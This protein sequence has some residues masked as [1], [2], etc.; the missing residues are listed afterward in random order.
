[1]RQGVKVK[2][3]TGCFGCWLLLTAKIPSEPFVSTPGKI[4]RV[5]NYT[6][7]NHF[8]HT[9]FYRMLVTYN[10]KQYFL[11]KTGVCNFQQDWL[12]NPSLSLKDTAVIEF[13]Y[14][15]SGFWRST[16]KVSIALRGLRIWQ[17]DVCYSNCAFVVTANVW[18]S[19]LWTRRSANDKWQSWILESWSAK[20][21]LFIRLRRDILGCRRW[22]ISARWQKW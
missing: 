11:Y 13:G 2:I 22:F 12:Q 17:R 1:M 18:K 16:Y 3:A 14:K 15:G 21:G 20:R 10:M 8:I 9:T 7:V 19:T 4:I 6:L 5:K